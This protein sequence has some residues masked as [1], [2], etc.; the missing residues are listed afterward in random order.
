MFQTTLHLEQPRP[1]T[2]ST[3]RTREVPT[4]RMDSTI[5]PTHP[6]TTRRRHTPTQIR[7]RANPSVVNV[8]HTIEE[9]HVIISVH[10]L[11]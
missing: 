11:Y 4:H 6:V 3:A 10:I 5:L 8:Y 9:L 7:S 2:T 1:I